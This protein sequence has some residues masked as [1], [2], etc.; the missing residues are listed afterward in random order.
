MIDVHA[1]IKGEGTAVMWSMSIIAVVN[2]R[3]WVSFYPLPLV[4][5]VELETGR[6]RANVRLHLP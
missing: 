1:K 6:W 2:G 5:R 3:G 4:R